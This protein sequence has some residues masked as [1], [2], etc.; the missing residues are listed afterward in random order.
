MQDY[1]NYKIYVIDDC[2]TDNTTQILDKYY[3]DGKIYYLKKRDENKGSVIGRKQLI[4][5]AKQDYILFIDNDDQFTLNSFKTYS[6]I[7]SKYPLDMVST[8]F[9]VQKTNQYLNFA[10]SQT[11]NQI[12]VTKGVFDYSFN[13]CHYF[14]L[15]NKAIKRTLAKKLNIQDCVV[16]GCDDHMFALQLYLNAKSIGIFRTQPNYIHH[17]GDGQWNKKM[18]DV[19]MRR[20][21]EGYKKTLLYNF[22]YIYNNKVEKKYFQLVYN[23]FGPQ[24]LKVLANHNVYLLQIYEQYFDAQF[25]RRLNQMI[26]DYE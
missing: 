23:R 2:S 16:Y 12:V 15:W 22:Q 25:Y 4:Q 5:L 3:N 24:Y 19:T 10:P 21:C 17:F 11:D 6:D 8:D 1:T 18:N 7:I 9:D 20:F 13:I 26:G 14:L